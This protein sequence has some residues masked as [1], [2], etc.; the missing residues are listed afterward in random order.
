MKIM[1]DEAAAAMAQR[2]V[3]SVEHLRKQLTDRIPMDPDTAQRVTAYYIKHR[4]A[5]LD[6]IMGTAS[7]VHGML[8]DDK[9][10]AA[11]IIITTPLASSRA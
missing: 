2:S 7:V 6:Q 5:K 1:S 8:L 10:I 9:A 4:F 11:V 3:R